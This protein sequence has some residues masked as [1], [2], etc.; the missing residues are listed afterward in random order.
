MLEHGDGECEDAKREQENVRGTGLLS[1]VG[2]FSDQASQHEG[3]QELLPLVE[4]VVERPRAEEA[5]EDLV[6]Q[7]LQ[8]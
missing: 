4:I 5:A 3:V 1:L 7:V 6:L 8:R 2:A